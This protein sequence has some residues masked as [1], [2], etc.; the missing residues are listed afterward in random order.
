M[1]NKLRL[2]GR[3]AAALAFLCCLAGGGRLISFAS[4][5]RQ[6]GD[7]SSLFWLGFGLYFIGKAFF[8]GPMLW[9]VTEQVCGRRESE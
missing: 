4:S 9:L 3:G 1:E 8:V 2:I 7:K 5:E 6:G